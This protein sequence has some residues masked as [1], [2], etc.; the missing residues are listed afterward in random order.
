MLVVLFIYILLYFCLQI[1][2]LLDDEKCEAEC[3]ELPQ[4]GEDGP[5]SDSP[6][7]THTD[8]NPAVRCGHTSLS[9]LLDHMMCQSHIRQRIWHVIKGMTCLGLKTKT[10]QFCVIF[11]Q[12]FRPTSNVVILSAARLSLI[13]RDF[14]WS[15][16][17]S[18]C[19]NNSSFTHRVISFY[20]AL[21]TVIFKKTNKYFNPKAH[22]KTSQTFKA[23]LHAYMWKIA[24]F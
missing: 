20:D 14:V 10:F 11:R 4:D 5:A 15:V 2:E 3:E 16:M 1:T 19:R 8:D 18:Q 13:K 17:D 21:E 22:Q 23:H 9:L 24:S 6:Q 12:P 7:R